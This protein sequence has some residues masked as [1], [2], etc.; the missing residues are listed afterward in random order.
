MEASGSYK[1][2]LMSKYFLLSE[3]NFMAFIKEEARKDHPTLPT[4]GF[5]EKHRKPRD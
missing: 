2:A 3:A 5:L 4:K 1:E